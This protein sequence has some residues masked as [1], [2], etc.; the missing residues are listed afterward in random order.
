MKAH[1][2]KPRW[3]LPTALLPPPDGGGPP[4]RIPPGD[5]TPPPAGTAEGGLPQRPSRRP[6]AGYRL[7]VARAWGRERLPAPGVSVEARSPDVSAD[8]R[9]H[10]PSPPGPDPL[11]GDFLLGAP[12]SNPGG[13]AIQWKSTLARNLGL[14]PSS[15]CDPRCASRRSGQPGG[16]AVRAGAEPERGRAHRPPGEAGRSGR[17]SGAG[18]S[19]AGVQRVPSRVAP[20]GPFSGSLVPR[21]GRPRGGETDA[22]RDG[23][24]MDPGVGASR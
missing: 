7:A 19:E 23:D 22:A 9:L 4:A 14:V 11:P 16:A 3:Q 18:R 2:R 17:R 5:L 1:A 12:S 21:D 8:L 6:L 13:C 10:R 20:P 15:R 24:G